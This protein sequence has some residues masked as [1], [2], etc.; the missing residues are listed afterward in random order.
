MI[1]TIM[2]I[3]TNTSDSI[4]STVIIPPTSHCPGLKHHHTTTTTTST[5]TT[6]ARGDLNIVHRTPPF[7]NKRRADRIGEGRREVDKRTRNRHKSI[8]NRSQTS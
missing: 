5:T 8:A 3:I 4:I 2:I 6:T 7:A 1:M